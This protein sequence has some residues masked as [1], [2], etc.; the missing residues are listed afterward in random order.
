MEVGTVV[1]M[2]FCLGAVGLGTESAALTLN[3]AWKHENEFLF[4]GN[5]VEL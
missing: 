4:W 2:G 5:R 1:V 3:S